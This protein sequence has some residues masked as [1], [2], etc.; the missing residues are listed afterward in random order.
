M[1]DMKVPMSD[2]PLADACQGLSQQQLLAN[3][4]ILA[5]GSQN[6]LL[7]ALGVEHCCAICLRDLDN[8]D[9]QMLPLHNLC[10]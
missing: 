7:V 5:D 3:E 2:T 10:D 4:I 6:R 9:K 8:K 1:E